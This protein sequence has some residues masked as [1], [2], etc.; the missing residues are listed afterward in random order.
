MAPKVTVNVLYFAAVRE[1]LG[2]PREEVELDA[3]A[4]AGT[5]IEL[6]ERKHPTLR[7]LI[8]HLRV[9]VNQEF[10]PM[11]RVLSSS[12][13]VVLIPPV[14]GGAGRFW[15]SGDPIRLQDVLDAVPKAGKGGIVTFS[16]IVRDTS[17]GQSV[18]RLE[19]EA[20]IPMAQKKLIEIGNRAEAQWPGSVLA[21]AHRIGVLQ[22]GELAVAIAAAAP[23]RQ[24]AFQACQFCIDRLKEEAPI[25]KK[26]IYVDGQAWVGLGP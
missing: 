19:Y 6:L 23:H 7:A 13:E 2:V 3:G 22:P 16:G 1:R 4:T 20:Y 25:W 8:P 24:E 10:A 17:R 5:L 14:A 15:L 21:I 26:E 9:A 12:D 18:R 11:D